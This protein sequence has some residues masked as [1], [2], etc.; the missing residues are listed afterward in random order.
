MVNSYFIIYDIKI[1]FDFGGK[2]KEATLPYIF[3]NSPIIQS[4]YIV[5][6]FFFINFYHLYR[7]N[8]ERK[9]NL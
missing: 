6:F 8:S 7:R 1:I 4:I 5:L 3:N 9:I 2:R